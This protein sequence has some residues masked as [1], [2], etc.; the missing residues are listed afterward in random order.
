VGKPIDGRNILNTGN[1]TINASSTRCANIPE[2][3]L[4]I[5]ME[6]GGQAV[7][8]QV[9]REVAN[10]KLVAIGV[11]LGLEGGDSVCKF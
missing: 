1:A 5:L 11:Y 3:G 2:M 10:V 6:A 4:R 9:G 7:E 8:A